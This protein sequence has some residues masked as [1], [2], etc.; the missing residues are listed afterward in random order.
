MPI[1]GCTGDYCTVL[2][3]SVFPTSVYEAITCVLLFCVLW[4]VRKRFTRTLQM[5]GTYLILVGIERF[6]VELVRVNSKYDWGFIKPTQAQILS[7]VIVFI[8]IGLLLF[9]K[10]KKPPTAVQV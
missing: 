7:V 2:P 9:Y 5:F 3:V 6:L 8:G 10:D 4:A 1:Q